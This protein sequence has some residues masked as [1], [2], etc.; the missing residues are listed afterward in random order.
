V[1]D[2]VGAGVAGLLDELG[3]GVVARAV[4]RMIKKRPVPD[5][6]S[7]TLPKITGSDHR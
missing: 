6:M 2:G 7:T 4:G 5:I 3:D 1:T